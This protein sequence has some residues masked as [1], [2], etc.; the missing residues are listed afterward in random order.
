MTDGRTELEKTRDEHHGCMKALAEVEN[1]LGH[2]SETEGSGHT[3]ILD[4]LK[5][6]NT[7]LRHHFQGEEEGLF[8]KL[9]VDHPHLAPRFTKLQD[10]HTAILELLQAVI[11]KKEAVDKQAEVSRPFELSAKVK[12]LVATLRRHEAEEDELMMEAHWR[13][14]GVSD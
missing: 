5:A 10:E 9:P 3:E 4:R 1:C 2:Y 11:R 6:L 14:V 7:T 12:L 13:T 8:R